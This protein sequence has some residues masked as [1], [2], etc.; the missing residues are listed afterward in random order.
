MQKTSY[1]LFDFAGKGPDRPKRF[2][3]MEGGVPSERLAAQDCRRRREADLAEI[4]AQAGARVKCRE[5]INLGL[6]PG[7]ELNVGD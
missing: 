2:R 7:G 1:D 6:R 4:K 3:V 5:R